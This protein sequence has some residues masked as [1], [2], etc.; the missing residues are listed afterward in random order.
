MAQEY[1][2]GEIVPQSGVYTITRDPMHTDM[3]YEVIVIKGRHC[4]GISFQPA[5]A[6][7][8]EIDHLEEAHARAH[9]LFPAPGWRGR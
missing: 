5:H 3:P 6:A 2:P 9:K 7:K 1:E 4:K 8:R